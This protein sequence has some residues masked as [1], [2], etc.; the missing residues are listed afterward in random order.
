MV[1]ILGSINSPQCDIWEQLIRPTVNQSMGA[2]S[3]GTALQAN[4]F[5]FPGF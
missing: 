3:P 5:Y 2:D 1:A 4:K